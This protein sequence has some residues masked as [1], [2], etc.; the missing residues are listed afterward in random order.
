MWEFEQMLKLLMLGA[1][2][3]PVSL[4]VPVNLGVLEILVELLMLVKLVVLVLLLIWSLVV[5]DAMCLMW[6]LERS[7]LS[8]LL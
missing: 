5:S 3:I 7:S 1:L 4:G 8:W 6:S 2:V